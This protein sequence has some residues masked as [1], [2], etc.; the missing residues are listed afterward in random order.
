MSN[1]E[2]IRQLYDAFSRRDSETIRGLMHPQIEWAQTK[3][4]P[5]GGRYVGPDEV[6][7][8]V[9]AP[10]REQWTEWGADVEDYLDAGDRVIALGC[11]RGVYKATGKRMEASFAHVYT[12]QDGRITRFVQYTDTAMLRDAMV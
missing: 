7:D 1:V 2:I 6:F 11:Y 9:F 10:F 3:G 12:L 4:F 8:K 5:G